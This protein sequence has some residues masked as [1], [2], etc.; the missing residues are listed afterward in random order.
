MI[1]WQSYHVQSV[2]IVCHVRLGWIF[3]KHLEADNQTATKGMDIAKELYATLEEKA[4][5]CKKC[6]HCEKECPQNIPISQVMTDI[7][8]VF[9]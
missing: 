8:K 7:V 4:D 3:P 2:H 6:H 1:P 9:S 5:A